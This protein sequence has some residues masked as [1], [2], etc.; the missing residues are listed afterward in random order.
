MER[1]LS[2]TGWVP[3]LVIR[4][5][6]SYWLDGSP[7]FQTSRFNR[8]PFVG[9]GVGVMLGVDVNVLDKVRV[10]VGVL[11]RVTVD[12][13]EAV[14]VFEVVGVKVAVLVGVFVLDQVGV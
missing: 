8:V 13:G 1:L 9:V 14:D 5:A 12:V 10:L 2:V 3:Q 7:G 11:V 6:T 4:A